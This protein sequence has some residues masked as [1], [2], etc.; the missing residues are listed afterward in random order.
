MKEIVHT[1]LYRI[2]SAV[3]AV[4][5]FL[6]VII[7]LVKRMWKHRGFT[8]FACYWLVGGIINL[9]DILGLVETTGGSWIN[10]AYNLFEAPFMLTVLYFTSQN[11]T[12]RKALIRVFVIFMTAEL[13]TTFITRLHA[14]TETV[15]VGLG[16]LI[17]LTFI[18]WEIISYLVRIEHSHFEKVMQFVYAGLVFEY[19][20]S[21]ITFIF[22]YIYPPP[23]DKDYTDNYYLYDISIIITITLVSWGFISY[24]EKQKK[25]PQKPPAR[26][27]NK[28]EEFMFI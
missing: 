4:S 20:I 10:R 25:P 23:P 2:V 6:P 26:K 9:I 5:F 21:I 28:D 1:Q 19:G 27:R 13:L 8:W 12:I 22:S 18:I 3:T 24:G 15:M 7:L 11:K 16:T 14:I 17:I